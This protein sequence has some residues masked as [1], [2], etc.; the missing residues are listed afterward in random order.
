MEL[1]VNPGDGFGGYV[2]CRELRGSWVEWDL[3]VC[4]VEMEVEVSKKS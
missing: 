1:G 2:I 4:K 3:G